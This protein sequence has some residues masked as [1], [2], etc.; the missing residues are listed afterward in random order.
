[1]RFVF[2][3][4]RVQDVHEQ[5]LALLHAKRLA[6]AESFVVDRIHRRTYFEAVRARVQHGGPFG[7]RTALGF[8]V[9]IHQLGSEERLPVA[10]REK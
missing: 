7:L 10:Q 1:M 2:D 9:I 6:K 3:R 8:V 5:A 4:A